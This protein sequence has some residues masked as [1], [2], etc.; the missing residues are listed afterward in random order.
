RS[1]VPGALTLFEQPANLF[2][3]NPGLAAAG[4]RGD[5]HVFKLQ[6]RQCLQLKRVGSERRRCRR[7]DA[8]EQ[9]AQLTT[10]IAGSRRRLFIAL[11]SWRNLAAAAG[12]FAAAF[13]LGL[14]KSARSPHA[15]IVGQQIGSNTRT[16]SSM[17]TTIPRFSDVVATFVWLTYYLYYRT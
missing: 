8:R 9:G 15:V 13:P 4:W 17:E 12:A 3:R 16:A 11:T 5:E 1:R 2:S 6:R 10:V 14:V 7:A